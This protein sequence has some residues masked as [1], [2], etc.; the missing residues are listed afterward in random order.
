[1]LAA[2]PQ[3]PATGDQ[4]IRDLDA[5]SERPGR[6]PMFGPWSEAATLA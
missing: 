1:M 6:P 2:W 4:V 3:Q 5:A